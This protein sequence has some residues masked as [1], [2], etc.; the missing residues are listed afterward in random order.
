V[1]KLRLEDNQR[2]VRKRL[3]E[4]GLAPQPRWFRPTPLPALLAAAAAGGPPGLAPHEEGGTSVHGGT[5]ALPPPTPRGGD[6]AAAAAAAPAYAYVGG[7]WEARERRDW[8]GVPRIF[9]GA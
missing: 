9:D 3:A 5:Q 4:Q 1:V 7:Y 6:A 8:T 2:A